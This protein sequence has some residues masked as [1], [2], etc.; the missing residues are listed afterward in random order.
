MKCFLCSQAIK[1][2]DETNSHHPVYKSDGGLKTEPT[3]KRCHILFHSKRGDFREWGKIGGQ[4]SA[5]SKQW[6]FNLKNVRQD[7]A[8]EINRAFYRMYYAH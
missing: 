1:P 8:H 6:A 5:L 4:I 3:H 2:G 7:A